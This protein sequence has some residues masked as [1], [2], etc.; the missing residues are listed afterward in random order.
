MRDFTDAEKQELQAKIE[1]QQER[2][3]QAVEEFARRKQAVEEFARR[4]EEASMSRTLSVLGSFWKY[5]FLAVILCLL[6]FN[7]IM[8]LIWRDPFPGQYAHPMYA[9]VVCALML[10]FNHIAFYITNGGWQSRVMKTIAVIFVVL[11]CA[12]VYWVFRVQIAQTAVAGG[13]GSLNYVVGSVA[14]F[15]TP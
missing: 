7:V 11:G 6:V 14:G 8:V 9:N 15:V 1:D 12:Y 5:G 4:Y 10:L 3:N 13:L 2:Q